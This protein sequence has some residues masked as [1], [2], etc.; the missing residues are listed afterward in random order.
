MGKV[1]SID[2]RKIL[3]YRHRTLDTKEVFYIGIG[4]YNRPYK[5]HGRT[6]YWKNIVNNN[7][8]TLKYLENGQAFTICFS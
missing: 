7:K 4:G 3:V 5:K 6:L 1:N 8:I 2:D